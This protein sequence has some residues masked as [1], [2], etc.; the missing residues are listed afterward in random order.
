MT[1]V[2]ADMMANDG[3]GILTEHATLTL[4]RLLPG[5]I[6][7]VWSYIT[8]SELRR[9]WLAAG[10]MEQKVGAPV[11]FIWRNDE[12]VCPPSERP[13]GFP[14]EHS[15]A[16]EILSIDAPHMLKISWG[17]TGGVTF[18]L[19]EQ[20]S[21]VMLTL[22]HHRVE[23]PDVLNNVSAGWHSHLDILTANLRGETPK[24]FWDEWR[25]LKG[26]YVEMHSA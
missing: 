3:Y 18:R 10:T 12:L 11:E 21:D 7:R 17:S 8:D 15:M 16:C 22:I 26:E 9:Q 4:H 19:E 23:D 13:E 1:A 2:S 14:A 6:E 25:R 24:P 5:P 20:G